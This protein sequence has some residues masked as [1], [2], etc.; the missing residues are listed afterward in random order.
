MLN[1]ELIARVWHRP[2]T[3]F[4]G[5]LDLPNDSVHKTLIVALAVSLVCSVVV[6][7]TVVLLKPLQQSDVSR[8][9]KRNI[10][11]VIG[12]LEDDKNMDVLFHGI[13][14]KLV[15][16]ASGDYVQVENIDPN[17]Y[18]PIK[19]TAI[20][21]LSSPVP[22]ER[23]V[24]NIG[25]REKY[26]AVYVVKRDDTMDYLILP[27]RGLGMYSTLHGLL[28]L[29]ADANTIFGFSVYQ[30]AETP[31]LGGK[32]DDPKWRALWKGK[33]IYDESDALRIQ[34]I[35]GSVDVYK[36]DA[37]YEVDGLTGATNTSRGV[38]NILRYWLGDDGYGPY[39]KKLRS[40][41]G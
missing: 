10:L 9:K 34:V 2:A 39:L 6:T 35:K 21:E 17:S 12:M 16:L 40:A 5:V 23:D 27:V 28:A 25:S 24:A 13:E 7:S 32:V 26:A 4:R 30:H 36:P 8:E 29:E 22:P 11:E 15:D 33:A 18:D 19:A 1:Q 20:P 31:G 14:T 37:K 3:W 41:R 38:N